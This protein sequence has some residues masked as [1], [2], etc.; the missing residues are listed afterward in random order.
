MAS[1]T[2]EQVELARELIQ[3]VPPGEVT[4][5]GDVAAHA[6]LSSPRLTAWILRTDGHDLPWWRVIAAS[7]RPS[8]RPPERQL[9]RLAAEGV[10]VVD[11]R[12]VLKECRH[13]F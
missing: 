5:Y 8:A 9:D 1:V 7:G 3:S 6:G 10:P 2:E 4:T 11:G 12:V 13:R